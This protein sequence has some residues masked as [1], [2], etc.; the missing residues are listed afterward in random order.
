[1]HN[2]CIKHLLTLKHIKNYQGKYFMFCLYVE[3]KKFELTGVNS[4]I[5]VTRGWCCTDGENGRLL[6]EDCNVE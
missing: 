6:I 1:M 2:K 3:S 5:M 4:R